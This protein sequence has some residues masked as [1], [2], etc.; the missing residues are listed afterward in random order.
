MAMVKLFQCIMS[1]GRRARIEIKDVGPQPPTGQPAM[2]CRMIQEGDDESVFELMSTSDMI[3]TEQRLKDALMH[4]SEHGVFLPSLEMID[5]N[6]GFEAVM[7][8]SAM[9]RLGL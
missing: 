1:S 3:G 4:I 7:K 5:S 9:Q 2:R 8:R 6:R